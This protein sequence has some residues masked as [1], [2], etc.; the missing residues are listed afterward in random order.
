MREHTQ[1]WELAWEVAGEGNTQGEVAEN[2]KAEDRSLYSVE[3]RSADREEEEE[4]EDQGIPVLQEVPSV[5]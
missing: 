2:S 5:P 4:L 1:A 3:Y